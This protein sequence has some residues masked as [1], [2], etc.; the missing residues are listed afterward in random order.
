[1]MLREKIMAIAPVESARRISISVSGIID[2]A[3][4]QTC[5]DCTY[6]PAWT[7]FHSPPVLI[8]PSMPLLVTRPV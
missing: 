1:M 4:N 6:R 3:K 7:A 8:V 2:T 5:R